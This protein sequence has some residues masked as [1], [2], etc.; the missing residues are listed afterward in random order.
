[1]ENTLQNKFRPFSY[2]PH[3]RA[4]VMMIAL[5]GLV[6]SSTLPLLLGA[7]LASFCL[8]LYVQFCWTLITKPF[9][10]DE[11]MLVRLVGKGRRSWE[12]FAEPAHLQTKDGEERLIRWDG[13][14]FSEIYD[15][16]GNLLGHEQTFD[17]A[18]WADWE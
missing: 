10:L 1:M 5:L 15:L 3:Q 13:W 12:R 8:V 11:P 16:K 4:L 17:S 6:I 9:P 2:I 18:D 7:P 14:S